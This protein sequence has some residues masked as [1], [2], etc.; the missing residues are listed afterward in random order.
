MQHHHRHHDRPQD[1]SRAWQTADAVHI[2]VRGLT[3][4]ERRPVPATIESGDLGA[5]LIVH[6]DEEPMHLYPELEDRGWT[7]E[8]IES[9]CGGPDC[10]DG[11]MLRMMRW[12]T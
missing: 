11:F 5:V 7:H 4:P 9:H 12:G 1:R 8:I 3:P 2:D 10:E 6:F